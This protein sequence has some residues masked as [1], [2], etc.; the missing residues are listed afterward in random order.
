MQV[1]SNFYIDRPP[2]ETR[3]AD[4]IVQPGAL[5]RIKAPRQMGKTSLMAR[6][7][8]EAQEQGAATVALSL[9]LADTKTFEDLDRL[10][11]WLCAT[12][13]RRLKLPNQIK[14]NWDDIFGSKYNCTN[15]FEEHILPVIDRPLVLG[16][17]EV[18]R[19]F[20]HPSIASDF[21]GL[22]RAWHEEAKNQHLWQNYD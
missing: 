21:F 16:F 14:S 11:Q 5:I 1:S 4:V 15:Y 10:L 12:I 19:V 20:E 13:S 6:T 18:D 22:L 2:I 9:Q 7:L 17:D 3:C 8:K